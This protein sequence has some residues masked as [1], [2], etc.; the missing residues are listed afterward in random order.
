[1]FRLAAHLALAIL[2][3]APKLTAQATTVVAVDGRRVEILRGGTGSP[4]VVLE[5]AAGDSAMEWR[6]VFNELARRNRVI[7][8]S[9]AGHGR[10]EAAAM[11][12]PQTAVTELHRLLATLRETGPIVLVG[13][14][15]GAL[16]ARL[17]ASTYP[18]ETAALVLVDGAHESM[19]ARWQHANPAFKIVDSLKAM[20]PAFPP[21]LRI[22]YEQ[23]IPVEEAERV[24]GM[25]ALPAR[26]PLVL[27]TALKPCPSDNPFAWT[28][29]DPKALAAWRQLHDEWVTSTDNVVHFIT[30]RSGHFVM[31]DEPAL[32]IE[33]VNTAVNRARQ[34]ASSRRPPNER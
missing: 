1:M 19:Y 6:G 11:N 24:E 3:V 20:L 10:S 2:V 14:S 12:S 7:A 5:S 18:T 32:V 26:M 15:W 13:H 33:A 22:D 9:R 21:P 8:Y 29:N 17:Y 34:Q 30:K 27:V 25:K 28:C 31:N 23:I 16:L 4:T